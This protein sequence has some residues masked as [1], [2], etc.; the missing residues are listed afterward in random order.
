MILFLFVDRK[1]T[2]KIYLVVEE[3]DILRYEIT[4]LEQVQKTRAAFSI[5]VNSLI[6]S[7]KR[8]KFNTNV[9]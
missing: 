6:R 7:I 2:V 4:R 8:K 9:S 1:K 5:S 3:I